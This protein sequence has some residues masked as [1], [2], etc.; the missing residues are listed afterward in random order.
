MIEHLQYTYEQLKSRSTVFSHHLEI[1]PWILYHATTSHVE[2]AIDSEGFEGCSTVV[3]KEHITQLIHI[4]ERMN[5]FGIRGGFSTLKGFTEGRSRIEKPQTWFRETSMRS[6]SYAHRHF[7]GGE[8]LMSFKG[9]FEDLLDFAKSKEIRQEH[10]DLQIHNC[11]DLVKLGA[12][13]SP[14][15]LVDVDSMLRALCPLQSVYEASQRYASSYKHGLLYAVRFQESD[16]PNLFDRGGSG[17]L[18]VGSLSSER[19][20]GK[21]CLS[22]GGIDR[23]EIWKLSYNQ[24]IKHRL[25]WDDSQLAHAI[26][27]NKRPAPYIPESKPDPEKWLGEDISNQLSRLLND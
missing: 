3:A 14:V 23:D 10:L 15:I 24:D 12:I 11:V 16:I 8:G 22:F 17:I 1:N 7:A 2:T 18:H 9:A 26:S 25:A 27:E 6:L 20:V 21:A 19:I 13:R 5:W 4:Y